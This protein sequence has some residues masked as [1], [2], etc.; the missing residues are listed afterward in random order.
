MTRVS[1]LKNA[2][3]N[4]LSK[5]KK[6]RRVQIGNV[7]L[8]M[9]LTKEDIKKLATEFIIGHYLND[10]KNNDPIHMIDI[11]GS[12]GIQSGDINTSNMVILE[13]SSVEEANRIQKVT[14]IEIIGVNCKII[15]CSEAVFGQESSL[16]A[17]VQNAKVI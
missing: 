15:R 5:T 9:G 16:V 10:P 17:K 6:A 4:L 8:Y 3:P 12:K 7:P 14:G 13:M 11:F 2:D 1:S